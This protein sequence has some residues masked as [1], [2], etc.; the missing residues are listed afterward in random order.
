M[1][2]FSAEQARKYPAW[3]QQNWRPFD[4]AAGSAA[5]AP[6]ARSIRTAKAHSAYLP[7][8]YTFA[9]TKL[10]AIKVIDTFE[11]LSVLLVAHHGRTAMIA[12]YNFMEPHDE[13][14]LSR[15]A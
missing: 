3:H 6:V 4:P 1:E 14:R 9:G 13:Q 15:C 2:T 12:L 8:L 7:R 10:M 5:K 11:P